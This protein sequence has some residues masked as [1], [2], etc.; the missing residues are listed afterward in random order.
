MAQGVGDGAANKMAALFNIHISPE[1]SSEQIETIF[2]SMA[3][4]LYGANN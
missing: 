4:H 2:A 3:K 1:S